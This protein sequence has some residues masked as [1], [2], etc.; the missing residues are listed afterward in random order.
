MMRNGESVNVSHLQLSKGCM[1]SKGLS[2][3]VSNLELSKGIL[4]RKGFRL[5]PIRQDYDV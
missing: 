5:G 1:E 3:T 4:V 2:V